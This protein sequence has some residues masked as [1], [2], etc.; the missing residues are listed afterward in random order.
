MFD[1]APTHD[2]ALMQ[3]PAFASALRL[4]GQS[5]IILPSGLMVL[6]RRILGVPMAMLPRAVPP[7]DL[8]DQLFAHNLH[9]TPMIL[10]PDSPCALPLALRLRRPQ[11]LAR[12]DLQ[13]DDDVARAALHPK[14]R[15]QLRRSEGTGLRI[16]DGPF[17][18]KPDHPL[19]MLETAQAQNR[20]Y[21]NWPA[22]LTAAFAQAAPHQTRLFTAYH[23]GT[24]VAYMLFLLHGYA[25]PI[26]SAISRMPENP[27]RRITYC[28]GE[29]LGGW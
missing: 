20:R 26:T 1:A 4:C 27:V 7:P 5:P 17:P 25:R 11:H 3:D 24:P 28:Y 12:W 18:A 19:L 23:R 2:T 29:H 13:T 9:R 16:S 22:G 10:S 8:D 21:A 15:N 6:Y 14:W